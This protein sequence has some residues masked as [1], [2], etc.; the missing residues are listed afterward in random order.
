MHVRNNRK[1]IVITYFYE[2]VTN[3]LVIPVSY[4]EY[5]IFEYFIF[6]NFI[7]HNLIKKIKTNRF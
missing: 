4:S 6:P 5:I 2:C 1:L 3:H 7:Y